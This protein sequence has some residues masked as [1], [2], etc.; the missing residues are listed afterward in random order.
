MLNSGNL[1]S[2]SPVNE[3]VDNL[4]IDNI[5]DS[6]GVNMNKNVGMIDVLSKKSGSESLGIMK[7]SDN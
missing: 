2:V 6:A 3:K 7:S 5:N 4:D 1:N